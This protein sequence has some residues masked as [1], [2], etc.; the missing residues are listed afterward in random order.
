MSY[1]LSLGWSR[2]GPG[3]WWALSS[4]CRD[5]RAYLH[6]MAGSPDLAAGAWG[7]RIG[8]AGNA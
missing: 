1:K 4:A 2:P 8:R 6:G 5:G 3:T 7:D